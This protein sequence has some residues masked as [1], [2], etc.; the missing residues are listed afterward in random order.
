MEAAAR[1]M[2]VKGFTP[3][4]QDRAELGKW[5]PTAAAAHAG[6]RHIDRIGAPQGA[7]VQRS[8]MARSFATETIA[9]A[10]R[11]HPELAGAA[12]AAAALDKHAEVDGVSPA[13]RAA[14]AAQRWMPEG[15]DPRGGSMPSTTARPGDSG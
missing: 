11:Q 6:G 7:A 3:T 5:A 15:R 10:V 9:E 12:A 2:Q 4:E 14:V 1:G 13:Q 8:L